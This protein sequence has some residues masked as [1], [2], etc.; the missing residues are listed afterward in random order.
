MR[1]V[2]LSLCASVVLC[3]SSIAQLPANVEATLKKT[4]SSSVMVAF[5]A[6]TAGSG[7]FSDIVVTLQIP[8]TYTQPTI[9]V[10]S[11]PLS[12]YLNG[13]GWSLTSAQETSGA[14]IGYYSYSFAVVPVGGP[15]YTF[16]TTEANVVEFQLTGGTAPIDS[17][18]LAIT[19]GQGATQG[20]I[21]YFE[22]NGS[23]VD[24]WNTPFY[25]T[26][27]ATLLNTAHPGDYSTYSFVKVGS[28]VSLPVK[29]LSFNAQKENQDALLKW[30]VDE[31][32]NDHFEIER[33]LD[34]VLFSKIAT[35]ASVASNS[36]SANY[37]D[38]DPEVGLKSS[39]A[40]Y[41][42]KQVDLDGKASYSPI[43][44]VQFDGT[45]VVSVY[46]N[47]V[48]EGFYVS[49]D[50]T[51]AAP[52]TMHL[53]N[54]TGQV[55][56]IQQVNNGVLYYNMS[57]KSLTSGTYMVQVFKGTELLETKKIFFDNSGK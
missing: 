56:D 55:V 12:T 29:W 51:I 25:A 34:G 40:Y 7:S 27:G 10:K 18:R 32:H 13:S 9:S 47:P 35:V 49:V 15:A 3:V 36:V 37:N 6:G 19:E 44:K 23:D 54:N 22:V 24:D 57:N 11:N 14:S 4:S 2:Y 38:I 42:I 30:T 39:N 20:G 33:S 8:G 26:G 50:A 31:E 5:K 46:P 17:V 53:T 1:K 52:V 43:R 28:T 45:S 41:R 21:V 48:K 16:S